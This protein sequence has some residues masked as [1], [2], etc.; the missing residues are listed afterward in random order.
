MATG[1]ER[2]KRTTTEKLERA[3]IGYLV[4]R[5]FSC[6]KELGLKRWGRRRAD[7]M[8]LHMSGEIILC[9]IKSG[10]DDYNRDEKWR[11]Y[12]EYSHKTYFV[13]SDAHF[14]SRAGERLCN[15]A[16]E[17]GVGVLVLCPKSGWL[18]VRVNAK[19]RRMTGQNKRDIVYRMAWRSG[20]FSARNTR[21]T[22]QYLE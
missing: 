15:E 5:K 6:F 8:G 4:K 7:I 17:E 16:R 19:R 11:E 9:E 13:I 21:R 10:A 12:L 18:R 2:M 20:E 1:K 14:N 3:A 22:R